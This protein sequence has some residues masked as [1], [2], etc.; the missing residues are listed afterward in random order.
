[1]PSSIIDARLDGS[2]PACHQHHAHWHYIWLATGLIVACAFLATDA[3]A[4]VVAGPNVNVGGGMACRRD[5]A[6]GDPDCPF[7]VFGDVTIQRQNEGS[8]ACSSRNP[9]TCL[10]A[11]N[12]YRLV[13]LPSPIGAERKVT[14]DAWLG[15]FWSRNGGQAW[16]STL[17]PGWK[18]DDAKV[19]DMSPQGAPAVNPIAGFQAAADPTVRAG[20]HGLFYL[21]GIAFNRDDEANGHRFT[22]ARPAAKAS[23]ACSS[24]RCSS[25]TTTRPIPTSRLV[26]CVRRSSTPERAGCGRTTG[27]Y[28]RSRR[29]KSLRSIG[30]GTVRL[31]PRSAKRSRRRRA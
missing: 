10:A 24:Y 6:G 12:D 8:M 21:S 17:L 20:T 4:Q 16:R 2:A 13:D 5:G 25:T 9:Q 22:A 7:Q 30:T 23:R 19:T 14:A 26:I 18:T 28:C 15:V 3:E 31:G 1:V 29:Q 11:G 27:T